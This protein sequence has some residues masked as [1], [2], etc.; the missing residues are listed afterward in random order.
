[1]S[2]NKNKG[3]YPLKRGVHTISSVKPLSILSVKDLPKR[4]MGYDIT[5]TCLNLNDLK[6][7]AST[8]EDFIQEIYKNKLLSFVYIDLCQKIRKRIKQREQSR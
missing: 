2:K 3:L 6:V 4:F 7:E 1:M 5:Y 8:H